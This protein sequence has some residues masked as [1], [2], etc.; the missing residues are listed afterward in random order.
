MSLAETIN[1]LNSQNKTD[2]FTLLHHADRMAHAQLMQ[3]LAG[4]FARQL[5]QQQTLPV[6]EAC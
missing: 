6:G 3:F 1:K 2:L 5:L 4:M